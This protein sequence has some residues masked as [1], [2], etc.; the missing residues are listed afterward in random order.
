MAKYKVLTKSF[1]NDR[2]VEEGDVVDY[3]G[4][5][6]P[7]LEPVKGKKAAQAAADSPEESGASDAPLV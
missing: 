6:G 4:V 3:D 7:N 1:I 5:A 2:I